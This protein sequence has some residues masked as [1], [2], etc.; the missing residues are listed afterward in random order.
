M[1]REARVTTQEIEENYIDLEEQNNHDRKGKI[2]QKQ[3]QKKGLAISDMPIEITLCASDDHTQEMKQFHKET[4]SLEAA[5]CSYT[6]CQE[7]FRGNKEVYKRSHGRVQFYRSTAI[8]TSF[9]L[10]IT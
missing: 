5:R 7:S 6:I 3:G 1:D 8:S 2:S 4:V 9:K 10:Q